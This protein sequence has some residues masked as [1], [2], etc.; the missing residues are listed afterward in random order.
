MTLHHKILQYASPEKDTFQYNHKTDIISK[1]LSSNLP[2]C[3]R[4]VSC[5]L[6]HP[7]YTKVQ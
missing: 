4:P 1:K 2:S 5:D 7:Y 6:Y 3:S